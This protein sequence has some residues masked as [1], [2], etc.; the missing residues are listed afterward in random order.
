[1]PT[2][3]SYASGALMWCRQERE[4]VSPSQLLYHLLH[5]PLYKTAS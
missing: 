2:F 4:P 1:M 3:K 5:H